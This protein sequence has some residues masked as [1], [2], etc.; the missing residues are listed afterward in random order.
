[1]DELIQRAKQQD[2][3]AFEELI[4][5]YMQSMYKTAR[6]YL[7]SDEDVVDAI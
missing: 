4:R 3:D 1:M 6:S 2:P 7:S 5:L